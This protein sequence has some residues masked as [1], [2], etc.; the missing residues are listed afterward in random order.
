MLD[1]KEKRELVSLTRAIVKKIDGCMNVDED[2]AHIIED[3]CKEQIEL[4]AGTVVVPQDGYYSDVYLVESGWAIRSRYMPNGTR[5][6]VNAVVPGDFMAFNAVLFNRSDFELKCKT[7]VCAYRISSDALSRALGRN[8]A[9]SALLFWIN[10]QEES[11]LTERIVSLGRRTAKERAAHVIC[12]LVARIEMISG[13]GTQIHTIP[14]SQDEIADI[15]G[16]SV[17][18]TN[19][20]LQALHREHII[21]FRNTKLTILDRA[22]LEREAGFENGYLH[23]TRRD[24][25]RTNTKVA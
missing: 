23:F 13:A 12:E 8:A 4:P 15:L 5:Q 22:Q 6:I 2:T 9:L 20:T 1:P 24:D 11:M 21:S 7:D 10:G 16:I 18:H 14:L 3:L 17:V 19:K 25:W